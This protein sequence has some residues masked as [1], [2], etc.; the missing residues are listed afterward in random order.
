MKKVRV[1][2]KLVPRENKREANHPNL[3]LFCESS[4][5]TAQFRATGGAD[6][7]CTVE[8]IA[9]LLAM[10]CL[11]RGQNPGEFQVLVPAEQSLVARLISRTEELL[12]EGRAIA[13]PTS[14][15][16]RQREVLD[17]VVGN[18]AN[19]EIASR[20][21]ITVR[22]VK[23]HV[24]SLLSKFGVDTR[25]ELARRAAGFMRPTLLE[26]EARDQAQSTKGNRGL[27]PEQA[28]QKTALAIANGSR[29]MRF[30]GR[31]LTA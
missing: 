2:P 27:V 21:N 3:F 20:L 14:L 5:G 1:F 6:L 9:G 19:K 23:F 18:R 7:E 15:S 10:Q 8:R 24:S 4:S 13:C 22:T 31:I 28:M 25:A 29:S 12:K 16:A 26:N 11:V 17:A 30:P